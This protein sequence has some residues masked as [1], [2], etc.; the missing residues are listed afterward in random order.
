MIDRPLVTSALVPTA[1]NLTRLADCLIASEAAVDPRLDVQ[2]PPGVA[3]NPT[4]S[5]DSGPR[6]SSRLAELEPESYRPWP[7]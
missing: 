6:R 2:R 1:V 3:M 7:M 5:P 4:A